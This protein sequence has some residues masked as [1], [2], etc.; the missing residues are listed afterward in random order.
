MQEFQN[1]LFLSDGTSYENIKT[2]RKSTKTIKN[3]TT[4]FRKKKKGSNSRL[5]QKAKVQKIYEKITNIRK[6]HL[7][8]VTTEIT[9]LYQTCVIE[10]FKN[11]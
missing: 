6:D 4:F 2:F 7:H 8:K 3:R 5:K 9:N 11:I 10:N 1:L